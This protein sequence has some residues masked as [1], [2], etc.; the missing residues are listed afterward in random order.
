ME[1]V[2]FQVE[3]DLRPGQEVQKLEVA[4]GQQEANKML[5]NIHS[6]CHEHTC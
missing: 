2:E 4:S 1:E 6:E 3:S 5:I